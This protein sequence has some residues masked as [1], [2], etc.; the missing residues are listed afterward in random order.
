MRE[1]YKDTITPQK[2]VER[3]SPYHFQRDR[4]LGNKQPRPPQAAIQPN[5]KPP[6][7][8]FGQM[9]TSVYWNEVF[10]DYL[11]KRRG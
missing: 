11:K 3:Q 8:G 10:Q 1:F 2:L 6:L 9:T 5:Q 4:Q 7:Q